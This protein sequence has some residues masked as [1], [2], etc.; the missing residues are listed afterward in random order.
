MGPILVTGASG[1]IGRALTP[2]LQ[3]V[4]LR[5]V[6]T[7][8]MA[9]DVDEPG[10]DLSVDASLL[11]ERVRPAAVVHLAGGTKGDLQ[12]ANI[13]TTVRV[14]EAGALLE[15][16]PYFVT[17]GSAAEYGAT[18]GMVTEESPTN[19]VSGYGRAKATQT[20][21]AS[22]IAC[23]KLLQLTVL[24][25]FNVVS[26]DLP[27]STALGRLSRLML[28]ATDPNP[29]LTCGR[30]DVVR[31]YISLEFLVSAIVQTVTLRPQGHTINVC[32]GSGIPLLAILEEMAFRLGLRPRFEVDPELAAIP[33]ASSVVGDPSKLRRLLAVSFVASPGR[34]A[35]LVLRKGVP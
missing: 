5:V 32:S 10:I 21:L 22:N 8:L 14:L 24:R 15:T 34:I 35:D 29:I 33:A 23:L 27:P 1:L 11:M 4:G 3:A 16:P 20:C 25:P 28:E 26:A 6:T 17:I 7:S 9:P 18:E 31:D 12:R 2:A 30:I 19:P 13:F